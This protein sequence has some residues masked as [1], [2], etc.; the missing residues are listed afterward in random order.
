MY[1][2]TSQR[3]TMAPA[4]SARAM[5]RMCSSVWPTAIPTPLATFVTDSTS[6]KSIGG[7]GDSS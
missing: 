5:H 7:P 3:N 6:H 1:Q 2:N 4:A